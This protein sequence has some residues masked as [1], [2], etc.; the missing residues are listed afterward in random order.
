MFPYPKKDIF[1]VSYQGKTTIKNNKVHDRILKYSNTFSPY[2]K[3][4]LVFEYLF[5]QQPTSCFEKFECYYS[6]ALTIGKI[7]TA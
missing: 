6:N 4:Y 5:L 3:N 7:F 2:L 1:S